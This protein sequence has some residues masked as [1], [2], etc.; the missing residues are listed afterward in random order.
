MKNVIASQNVFVSR[1]NQITKRKNASYQR[2][3]LIQRIN[4]DEDE[5]DKTKAIERTIS[6]RQNRS[7][8]ILFKIQLMF[9]LFV[10]AVA[11]MTILWTSSMRNIKS[12]VGQDSHS[13]SLTK[14]VSLL[15]R[16]FKK[17]KLQT[18]Q[19]L[20]I[21]MATNIPKSL[22]TSVE[23]KTWWSSSIHYLIPPSSEYDSVRNLVRNMIY[24]TSS[25][26]NIAL[27]L[28]DKADMRLFL[29]S[30][31][32]KQCSSALS[33]NTQENTLLHFFDNIEGDTLT[34]EQIHIWF[35]CSVYLG[36]ANGLI[37]LNNFKIRFG[38]DFLGK[39][40]SYAYNGS[41]TNDSFPNIIMKMN[42]DDSTHVEDRFYEI[43]N[44]S[45]IIIVTNDEKVIGEKI[46]NSLLH[47]K[48]LDGNEWN[49]D[50]KK[51][52]VLDLSC[53]Q[54]MIDNIQTVASIICYSP[55]KATNQ[56]YI[57]VGNC[58]YAIASS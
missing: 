14:S 19:K 36:R 51:F 30:Q 16:V 4:R 17:K 20:R 29:G 44:A 5:D 13:S 1:T 58:C 55:I 52:N 42:K 45:P 32:G 40:I 22:L 57:E 23:Y 21:S 38:Y 25:N 49:G 9:I 47:L 50:G 12:G 41:S 31:E 26:T 11:I 15:S 48:S 35:W 18:R 6:Q 39:M 8:N 53:E 33:E 28:S 3:L 27:E 24:L 46:L 10:L 2:N 34:S 43:I 37:D 7:A 54:G 56:N